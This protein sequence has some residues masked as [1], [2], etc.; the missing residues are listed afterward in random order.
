ME[1]SEHKIKFQNST[2][3]NFH[4][5]RIRKYKE[6]KTKTECL[7]LFSR[8]QYLKFVICV[9]AQSVIDNI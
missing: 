6:N 8:C 3:F 7:S 1:A 4:N 5:R 2:F 9:S